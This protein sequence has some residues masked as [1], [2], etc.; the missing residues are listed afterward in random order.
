MLT[1]NKILSI[2]VKTQDAYSYSRYGFVAWK[3]AIE[4]LDN[5]GYSQ[6]QIVEILKHKY[7]RRAADSFE[8]VVNL[9]NGEDVSYCTGDEILEYANKYGLSDFRIR[10]K[11]TQ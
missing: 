7:M 9:P 10:E 3:K 6:S 2:V 8:T 4:N 5:M 1:E 11:K